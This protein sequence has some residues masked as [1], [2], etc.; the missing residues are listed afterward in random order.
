MVALNWIFHFL[1]LICFVVCGEMRRGMNWNE[2]P[3][4]IS[5]SLRWKEKEKG[6]KNECKFLLFLE[7][8]RIAAVE[9]E[10]YAAEWVFRGKRSCGLIETAPRCLCQPVASGAHLHSRGWPVGGRWEVGGQEVAPTSTIHPDGTRWPFWH[11]GSDLRQP[12]E[13]EAERAM[14][15]PAGVPL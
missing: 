8:N 5:F 7:C 14:G 10:E 15:R 11:L 12:P 9:N 2:I 13:T 3:K 1:V 6:E 4:F